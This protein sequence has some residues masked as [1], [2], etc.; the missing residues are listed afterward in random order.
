MSAVREILDYLADLDPYAVT[1]FTLSDP[2]CDRGSYSDVAFAMT[3]EPST[4]AEV[5]AVIASV[6]GE[7]YQGYKGGDFT[8]HAWTDCCIGESSYDVGD[9][10]SVGWLRAE[11]LI[12]TLT[13]QR[14]AA[15]DIA[16]RLEGELAR[17]RDEIRSALEA[18][19]SR[20]A[21]DW[22]TVVGDLAVHSALSH[23]LRLIDGDTDPDAVIAEGES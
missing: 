23:L 13:A 19:E 16:A 18:M 12:A 21:D 3:R 17:V 2:H 10:L 7:T 4:V 9:A 6:I 5:Y 15:R 1:S 22:V 11:M 8:M 14:D 20:S